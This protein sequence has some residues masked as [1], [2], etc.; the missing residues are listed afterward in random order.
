MNLFFD[1]NVILDYL[2]PTNSFHKEACEIMHAVFEGVVTGFVSSHSLTDIFYISRK[3]FSVADRTLPCMLL[4]SPSRFQPRA[5]AD[6][7][8][9]SGLLGSLDLSDSLGSSD[10]SC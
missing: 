9:P 6:L 1:T 3:Y 4:L 2:I 5:S 10:P 8:E 7:S